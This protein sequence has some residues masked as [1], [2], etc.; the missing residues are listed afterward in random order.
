MVA[1]SGIN[2]T[3]SMYT[4]N[5]L[6]LVVSSMG[7]DVTLLSNHNSKGSVWTGVLGVECLLAGLETDELWDANTD[8]SGL[9]MIASCSDSEGS[10]VGLEIRKHCSTFI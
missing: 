5:E 7:D 8:G 2:R 1:L 9:G 4:S 10:C 6:W 3:S